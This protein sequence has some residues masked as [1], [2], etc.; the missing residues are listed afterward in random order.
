MSLSYKILE[1][2]LPVSNYEST[3]RVTDNG[4]G[5]SKVVWNSTF[6]ANGASDDEAI[7]IITGIYAAGLD[8]VN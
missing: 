7:N 6:D 3:I 8:A 4:D 5:G 1:G 2:P